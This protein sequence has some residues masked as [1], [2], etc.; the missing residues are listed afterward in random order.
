MKRGQRKKA[1][2]SRKGEWQNS[3]MGIGKE[4]RARCCQG[5]VYNS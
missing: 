4:S 2:Q 5:L 3:E 1:E